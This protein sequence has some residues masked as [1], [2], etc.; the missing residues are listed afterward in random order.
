[1][2]SISAEKEQTNIGTYQWYNMIVNATPTN[3]L[4]GIKS[5]GSIFGS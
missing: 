3:G 2:K 1:M 4:A 5:T